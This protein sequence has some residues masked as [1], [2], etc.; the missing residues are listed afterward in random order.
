MSIQSQFMA[1]QIIAQAMMDRTGFFSQLYGMFQKC[2]LAWPPNAHNPQKLL[3]I[4]VIH[5]T[6]IYFTSN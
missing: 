3:L 5:G 4:V 1:W 2:I 6:D